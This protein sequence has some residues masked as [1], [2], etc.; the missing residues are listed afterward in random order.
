MMH[1]CDSLQFIMQYAG[2]YL[3]VTEE[4]LYLHLHSYYNDEE[5]HVD[6]ANEP[7]LKTYSRESG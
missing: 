4:I 2:T 1:H 6:S 7:K 3:F 5:W